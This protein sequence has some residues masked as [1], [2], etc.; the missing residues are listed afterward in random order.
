MADLKSVSF[1]QKRDDGLQLGSSQPWSEKYRPQTL[2]E[3]AAH[4][5]IIVTSEY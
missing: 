1:V 4:K 2:D 3:V 5:D